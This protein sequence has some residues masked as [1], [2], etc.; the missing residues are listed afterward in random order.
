[1]ATGAPVAKRLGLDGTGELGRRF[2]GKAD[3]ANKSSG[4]ETEQ[5]IIMEQGRLSGR[6]IVSPALPAIANLKS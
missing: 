4:V 3:D 6:G 1:M 5:S 2:G